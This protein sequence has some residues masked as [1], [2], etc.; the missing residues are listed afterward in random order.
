LR[1]EE[2]L[3]FFKIRPP[4][5]DQR[6]RTFSR[7]RAFWHRNII[8]AVHN[9]SCVIDIQCGRGTFGHGNF[10]VNL[11]EGE[12]SVILLVHDMPETWTTFIVA[13]H[14]VWTQCYGENP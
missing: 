13:F 9:F 10:I 11:I 12:G 4:G 7:R 6:E 1:Y 2:G 8:V 14:L 3:P 5:K